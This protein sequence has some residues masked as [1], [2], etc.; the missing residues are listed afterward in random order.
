V[1]VKEGRSQLHV[2][3]KGVK[4]SLIKLDFK[5]KFPSGKRF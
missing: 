5:P 1:K 2:R 4:K 3:K